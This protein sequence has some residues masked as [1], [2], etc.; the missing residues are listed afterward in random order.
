MGGVPSESDLSIEECEARAGEVFSEAIVTGLGDNNWK[1]RLASMEEANGKLAIA[2]EFPGLVAVKLLCKKPGLKDNNF[3]VL[4]AKL[5]AM[6]TIASNL[7]ELLRGV[8]AHATKFVSVLKQ[9]DIEKAQLG[10]LFA[11][12]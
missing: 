1:T 11:N 2:T 7:H 10:F 12:T 4:G 9:G 3:Q 8:R 5:A 6:K